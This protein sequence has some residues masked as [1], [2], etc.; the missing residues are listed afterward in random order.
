MQRGKIVDSFLVFA[1]C[2]EQVQSKSHVLKSLGGRKEF[3]V[4]K[5]LYLLHASKA[6]S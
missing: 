4:L 6:N 3:A 5:S 2:H 1:Y